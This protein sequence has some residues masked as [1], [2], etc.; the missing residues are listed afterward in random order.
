ME[1]NVSVYSFVRYMPR[2]RFFW[3]LRRHVMKKWTT[4]VVHSDCR[5][6]ITS[7][8]TGHPRFR[9]YNIHRKLPKR[10][11]RHILADTRCFSNLAILTRP[12]LL[13]YSMFRLTNFHWTLLGNQAGMMKA[14]TEVYWLFRVLLGARLLGARLNTV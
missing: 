5:Q 1:N 14:Q 3:L 7:S 11:S 10:L 8:V 2:G 4:S 13:R 6:S 9:Y 12:Y